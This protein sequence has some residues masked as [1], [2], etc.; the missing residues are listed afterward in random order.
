M[1]VQRR[2]MPC[3]DKG[4]KHDIGW[5]CSPVGSACRSNEGEC[6]AK[7]KD[8][9]TTL[10]GFALPLDLHAG[11]TKE[12]ALPRQRTKARH[13]MA[14]LSRWICMQVERRRMPCQDKGQKHDI[15]WLC[16]PVGSAC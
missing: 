14:L 4:Q 5:L 15:G 12:N 16:S 2:R 10:D 3:Q 7:T 13:W 9:S 6:P 1:Q 8:K 11:R